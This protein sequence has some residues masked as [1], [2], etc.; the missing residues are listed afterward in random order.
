MLKKLKEVV[1]GKSTRQ[2]FDKK[3]KPKEEA[4]RTF[5]G[6]TTE[7]I[8][9]DLKGDV[10]GSDFLAPPKIGE[11]A[12]MSLTQAQETTKRELAPRIGASSSSLA[13][14]I[15]TLFSEG[16]QTTSIK[17]ITDHL[18]EHKG[19]VDKRFWYMLMDGHQVSGNRQIF[20]KVALAFSQ[21]FETSSPSWFSNTAEVKPV[22]MMAGKNIIIL[23]S[24]FKVTQTE[25][26]KEFLK[27]SREEKFC[28]INVSQCKF[29][30]SEPAALQALHKLFKDLR[31]YEVKAVLMGDNNLINFCKSYINPSPENKALKPEFLALEE[32]F[33]LLYLEILQWKGRQED[34]ENIALDY[35]M[36]FEVSPPGWEDNGVM[37]IEIV[38]EKSDDDSQELFE[39]VLNS[40]NIQSLLDI[41]KT[42]FETSE[43][44]EIE[45][46]HVERIDFASAGSIS[47]FIQELWSDDKFANRKV[48]LR[49]PNEMILTLLEMVGAT[50]F[51]EIIP[52]KR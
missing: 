26:F 6:R 2:D 30:S 31:K 41:I 49:H 38:A 18:N 44:C 33:W 21:K 5:G 46:G 52:R 34:F 3:V 28:R 16:E 39:K 35:A 11:S 32:L 13:E 15:A 12:Q 24:N 23:E 48:I 20:E 45:F 29:E 1:A 9:K 50:E 14:E 47:F 25:R 8:Q 40:N 17:I 22:T 43:K 36:K 27:A 19:N 7:Q 51:I 4:F 37:K 42:K 10:K